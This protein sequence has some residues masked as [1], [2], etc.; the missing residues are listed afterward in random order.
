MERSIHTVIVSVLDLY[1]HDEI[2][3]WK[4]YPQY[5]PFVKWIH[6]RRLDSIIKGPA[7]C[8]FDFFCAVELKKIAKQQL[9][10]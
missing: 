8:L 2:L 6:R 10:Y 9:N 7:M 3:A 1:A 5:R 4:R